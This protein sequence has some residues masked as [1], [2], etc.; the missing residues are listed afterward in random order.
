MVKDLKSRKRL[1]NKYQKEGISRFF[2]K[3]KIGEKVMIN[4]DSSSQKNMP[5]PRFH[6]RIGEIID[7][8]GRAYLIKIKDRFKEKVLTVTPNH[9]R[10]IS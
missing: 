6:G 10:K 8:R 1:R 5:H 2:R 3:L 9:L 4:I 7:K